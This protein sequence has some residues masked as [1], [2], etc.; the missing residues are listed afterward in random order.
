M[1]ARRESETT[2]VKNP[3][4]AERKSERELVVTR[5][6]NAPA[7]IVFEAWTKPELLKRWWAPKSFGVSLLSCEVDVRVGGT[8]RLVFGHADS[9][10]M[11][12]FGRYI[13]VTPHSR[14]VWTND[15]GGEEG[16]VT[17]ATFEEKAGKTLLV[18]H[19]LYPTKEALDAAIASGSTSGF[20][21]TFDQLDELLLTLGA[22]AGR[23]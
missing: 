9:K 22:S 1:D 20:S 16:A 8:Y 7:R 12:F 21:E 17:T 2:P 3:T 23:S 13:E 18:L 10:P 15:E 11:E 4:T 5:S 19:D 14:L 6:F